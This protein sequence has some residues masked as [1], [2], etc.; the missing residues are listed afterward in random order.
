MLS[1]NVSTRQSLFKQ[2]FKMSCMLCILLIGTASL[3][4]AQ[5]RA[6]LSDAP[7]Y[8]PEKPIAGQ[9]ELVGSTLMQPLA[10]LWMEDFTKIHPELVSKVDCQGSEESFKKLT[11]SPNVIGLLS[12]EVTAD[13]LARWNK[14]H[15]KKLIAIEVGYDILSMIVHKD[16]PIRALAWNSHAKSPMSLSNDKPIEKWSDLGVDGNGQ[17][18]KHV[19]VRVVENVAGDL[20]NTGA[21]EHTLRSEMRRQFTL[22]KDG[23]LTKH[24]QRPHRYEVLALGLDAPDDGETQ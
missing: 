18:R 11:D 7:A 13:E 9:I 15:N 4:R 16:N 8:A 20:G 22:I 14:E 6:G 19:V 10:T 21:V 1:L 24:A 23:Y 12:R 17:G 2:C 3:I 5:D